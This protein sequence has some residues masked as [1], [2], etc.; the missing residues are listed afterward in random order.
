MLRSSSFVA[1]ALFVIQAAI[2]LAIEPGKYLIENN[3]G[4]VLGVGPI[5]RNR[6]PEV[7]VRLFPSS[8]HFGD[9]WDVKRGDDGALL[10]STH[11]Q[12]ETFSLVNYGKGI[13]ASSLK[14][15]ELWTI[16]SVGNDKVEI[17]SPNSDEVF[18]SKP[19]EQY[20]VQLRP[21]EGR[22]EQKW[23]FVPVERDDNYYRGSTNRFCRQ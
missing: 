11:S 7:P 6:L 12:S 13:F 16:T 23:K 22:D 9:I 5:P 8:S 18:T 2:V 20:P 17:K 15:P 19:Y 10:I 3:E 14:A 4:F 1:L 21:A